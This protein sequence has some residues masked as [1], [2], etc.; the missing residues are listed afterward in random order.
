[1]ENIQELKNF[2]NTFDR[3]RMTNLSFIRPT[4]SSKYN[5]MAKKAVIDVIINGKDQA[6]MGYSSG[7]MRSHWLVRCDNGELVVV[8]HAYGEFE[9]TYYFTRD[10]MCELFDDNEEPPNWKESEDVVKM[11]K[12]NYTSETA[13]DTT[14][15]TD[16]EDLLPAYIALLILFKTYISNLT[17]ISWAFFIGVMNSHQVSFVMRKCEELKEKSYKYFDS[18]N[19]DTKS[20][21]GVKIMG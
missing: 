7:E 17:T 2:I 20:E 10:E 5:E 16:N 3:Q 15:L 14:E 12:E 19:K 9:D 8:L 4:L 13:N 18:F 21:N 6:A 11:I 1:M